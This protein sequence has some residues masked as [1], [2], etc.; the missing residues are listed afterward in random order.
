MKKDNFKKIQKLVQKQNK[1][2]EKDRK[3]FERNTNKAAKTIMNNDIKKDPNEI[4]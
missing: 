4:C 3:K 1:Q 2:Y